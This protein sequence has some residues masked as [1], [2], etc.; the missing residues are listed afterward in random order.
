MDPPVALAVCR[1]SIGDRVSFVTPYPDRPGWRHVSGP[2]LFPSLDEVW[3]SWGGPWDLLE[4][5]GEG[6][7]LLCPADADR[8]QVVRVILAGAA[9]GD[10]RA[11]GP[12]EALRMFSQ[13]PLA[14]ARRPS[15]SGPAPA[16]RGWRTEP[17]ETV[18]QDVCTALG[19]NLVWKTVELGWPHP[20]PYLF[21]PL[22]RGDGP[23]GPGLTESPAY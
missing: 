2:S 16:S 6:P 15:C 21:Y 3:A 9:G 13:G 1:P 11:Y 5:W 23:R 18:E 10:Q 19:R 4:G 17:V 7:R 20:P 8:P 12:P 14:R 22:R